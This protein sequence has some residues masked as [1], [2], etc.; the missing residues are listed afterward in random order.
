MKR[1]GLWKAGAVSLACLG[2]LI[3]T[4]MLNAARAASGDRPAEKPVPV[5]ADVAL[6]AG[7]RLVGQAVDAAGRPLAAAPV[8]L[9]QADREVAATTADQQGRFA[10]RG[11]R[12]GT[13]RIAAGEAQGVYRLWAP[14]TAPPSARPAALVV[15]GDADRVLGQA[16]PHGPLAY[17]FCCN[18]WILAGL[19]AAAIAIPVAIHNHQVDRAEPPLSP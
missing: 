15:A 18:P 14:G 10:V 11:L 8:I 17:W 9:Q 2:L 1:M 6:G 5:A 4:P 19:V 12:G 16:G 7:G 13:Y 3:P